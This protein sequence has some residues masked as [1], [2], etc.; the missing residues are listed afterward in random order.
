MSPP[1]S[2]WRPTRCSLVAEERREHSHL[3]E[4]WMKSIGVGVPG[5]VTPKVAIGAVVGNDARRD[6]PR[7]AGRLGVLAVPHRVG[8]RR[9]LAGRG[10]REGG[11]RG[12]R[13][14]AASPSSC[15][16]SSTASAWASPASR[17][18]ML[19]FHCTATGGEVRPHPLETAD[20]GWFA[21]DRLP[22]AH[23]R[24][25]V[26]GPDGVRGDRRASASTR[27]FDHVRSPI[28]RS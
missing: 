20:V 4:E 21:E 2:R 10:R 1:T 23:G 16:L 27:S 25:A 28:W 14:R 11:R 3:V 8:R 6:P 19:L 5:Y 24:R 9:V 17:M 18:Y 13:H 15:S 22:D 7:A 26:V 12:D